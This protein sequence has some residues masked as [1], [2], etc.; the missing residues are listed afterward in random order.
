VAMPN[1]GE[2]NHITRRRLNGWRLCMVRRLTA[3]GLKLSEATVC[4]N[5]SGLLVENALRAPDDD[6]RVSVLTNRS[7]TLSSAFAFEW[8]GSHNRFMCGRYRLSRRKQLVEE[9][10]GTV[11]GG[12]DWDPTTS[13]LRSRL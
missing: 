10:S 13:L 7:V 2:Y 11:S 3:R 5:V 4:V 8:G 9:Y 6:P 1:R 12:D